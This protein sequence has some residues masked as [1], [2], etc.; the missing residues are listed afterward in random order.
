MPKIPT[1]RTEATITGEVGSVKSNIQMGLNQT[2]GNVLAPVTKE[3]VQHRVKQKDFENKTE[4]LRLEN[5]FVRDM[6]SVYDQA[7]NLE[8]QDQAQNLVKTQSNILMKKYSG[9]ASNRGTQDLFNQYALSEVQKG[10]FR[11]TTAVEKNTLIALDTLVNEKKQK[12]MITAIDTDEGF[13]YAVLGSDLENLYTTN[14]KGKV[15]DAVLGKMIAGIPNEIKFLEAEK[16]IANNPREA[17]EMLK[18]E[19]DFVGLNYDSRIQLIEKAKTK[20]A[21][22]VK[23]QWEIHTANINEG[24]DVEPFNLDLASEVLPDEVVNK[25]I[26]AETLHRETSDNRKIIL[27]TPNNIVDEVTEG[28]IEEAKTKYMPKEFEEIKDYYISILEN[29]NKNLNSDP[30]QYLMSIDTEIESL[31]SQ[32]GTESDAGNMEKVTSLQLELSNI[33]INKQNELGVHPSKQKVMTNNMAKNFI[34]NYKLASQEKDV[35]KQ[36]NM[37]SA[38]EI[39]YGDL[40]PQVFAQLMHAGLPQAAKF[41][42]SGFATQ[43]DAMKILSLDQPEKIEALKKFLNDSDD[44]DVSFKKMRTEIRNNPDFKDIENI[45]RRNVPF[46]TGES[47]VEMENIVDFLAVY[48]ANEFYAGEAKTFQ[49]AA[50]SAALMFTKNFDMEDTYY[51]PVSYKDSI[52]GL[53]VSTGKKDK[54]ISMANTIKDFYLQDFKAVAF[55]S[56]KDGVTEAELTETMEFQM[57]ENGEWR[58]T[59]DGTG[60]VYGIVMSG[61]TFATI[62]NDKGEELY[63]PFDYNK[64]TVPGTDVVVD[65]DIASKVQMSRGYINIDNATQDNVIM[66][67]RTNEIPASVFKN[68]ISI[69][70]VASAL[71]TNAEAS[72]MPIMTNDKIAKDWS[73]LYQ[74]SNDPVK[75]QRAKDILNTDYTVPLEAKNSIAIGAKIFEG[76]K[77]LSQTQLIQYGSAIGQ[78]ESG[79]K[80]KRQGLETVDDGKGV[81]R[82]YWQ[83]EP[84]TAL[85]LFRNSSAIFGEKFEKQFAKYN[86]G[87]AIGKTSVKYLASLSEEKMSKLL[88]SD[89]DLAATVALGVIVNRTKSKKKKTLS[90]NQIRINEQFRIRDFIIEDFNLSDKE[91]Y[92]Y[93]KIIDSYTYGANFKRGNKYKGNDKIILKYLPKSKISNR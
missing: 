12:L 32:I 41:L 43:E 39:Q 34:N 42:S 9:L 22:I 91:A 23:K 58:N 67:K 3:I 62:V 55:N 92:D 6:Q 52:T 11:T 16:M 56:K 13:D 64:N 80:Y 8:N 24:K 33:L 25:M 57:K 68:N 78:I 45:I 19:K 93:S 2:I 72:E 27:N 90:F 71:S 48:G 51:F 21:P 40:E 63:I 50:K 7:G 46:D 20:L 61:N 18:D 89:S 4:A 82:S 10:I 81:A 66:G 75:E 73:T 5:D 38:L 85:D 54:I 14:Y 74:T 15:S 26:T 60:I 70:D 17:L 65:T 49:E 29:R 37:L 1:F 59:A 35:N 84:K 28:F 53:P 77:G 31:V 88:E 87:Y 69:S 44:T 83:I 86:R 79:Y 36:F 30:V 47:S 76:D